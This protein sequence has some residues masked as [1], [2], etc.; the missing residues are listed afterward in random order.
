MV[1]LYCHNFHAVYSEK[2]LPLKKKN[3]FFHGEM[4]QDIMKKLRPIRVGKEAKALKLL[5]FGWYMANS[6]KNSSNAMQI[7]WKPVENKWLK[8]STSIR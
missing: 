2:I 3:V 1:I 8:F 7:A 4:N 6:S 5:N